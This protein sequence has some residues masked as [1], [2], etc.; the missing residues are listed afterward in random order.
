MVRTLLR[1]IDSSLY[2]SRDS[3]FLGCH[4]IHPKH[5]RTSNFHWELFGHN[6]LPRSMVVF[7]GHLDLDDDG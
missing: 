5:V 4:D 2:Y 6:G 3:T 7:A 1:R